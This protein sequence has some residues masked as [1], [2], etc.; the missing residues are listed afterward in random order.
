MTRVRVQTFEET[1]T[2]GQVFIRD[3]ASP[4]GG[5]WG[6]S[7]GGGGGATITAATI[8]VPFGRHERTVTIVDVSCTATSKV[9]VGWGATLPTDENQPSM[10][11]VDFSAVPAAGSLD[12]TVSSDEAVGGAYKILYT[13]G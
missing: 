11:R 13:L 9:L 7:G 12:V 10:G 3:T 1:G 2:T 4:T 8:D 6:A 5:A